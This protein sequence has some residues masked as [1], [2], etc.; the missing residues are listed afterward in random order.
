M[1][2]FLARNGLAARVDSPRTG[3]KHTGAW[4]E[5][6]TDADE[7]AAL[8]GSWDAEEWAEWQQRERVEQAARQRE[9]AATVVMLIAAGGVVDQLRQQVEQR[10]DV[11]R[12]AAFVAA[13]AAAQ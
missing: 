12:A 10:V 7:D 8:L 1:L 5:L 4:G 13:G 2:Y 9:A 11:L 3:W 6:G